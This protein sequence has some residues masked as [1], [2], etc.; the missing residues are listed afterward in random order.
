M[1]DRQEE[2][3]EAVSL[4]LF[5]FSALLYFPFSEWV[6]TT[7][8][9]TIFFL[10]G[11]MV[12]LFP[13]LMAIPAIPV[14]IVCLA[15]SKIRRRSLLLL[16]VCILYVPCCLGGSILGKNVRRAGMQ[17]FAERSRTLIAAIEKY[18]R[19]HAAAPS[20]LND[21]IPDY[22]DAVPSTGMMAYPEYHYYVGAEAQ[23]PYDQN[24][25]VL[26][27]YTPGG[28][29]NFDMML[30]FPRQNYPKHGYGGWLEPID[31]WAYVHE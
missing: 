6:S 27:V 21:L 3:R 11:Q 1:P 31:N 17:A 7:P 5:A 22:L 24:P 13:L 28:G 4:V 2:R 26:V 10:W 8:V 20:S 23:H 30:Y 29:I 15:F 12:Y 9:G 19:D 18:E 14:L 25:W 16:I